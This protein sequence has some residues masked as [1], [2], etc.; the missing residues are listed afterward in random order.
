MTTKNYPYT[1]LQTRLAETL[2]VIVAV[3]AGAFCSCLAESGPEPSAAGDPREGNSSPA[4]ALLLFGHEC[5][6]PRPRPTQ[7]PLRSGNLDLALT[8]SGLLTPTEQDKFALFLHL[9]SQHVAT[10]VD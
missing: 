1:V 7:P 2:V 8:S 5:R 4:K 6:C 10:K 3:C 9:N